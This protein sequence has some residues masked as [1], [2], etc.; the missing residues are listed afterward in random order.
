MRAMEAEAA[1][2]EAERV[3]NLVSY[4]EFS[5]KIQAMDAAYTQRQAK[6]QALNDEKGKVYDRYRS[7]YD[8]LNNKMQKIQSKYFNQD[9]LRTDD[10]IDN[11]PEYKSLLKQMQKLSDAEK[12]EMDRLDTEAQIPYASDYQVPG[13]KEYKDM[14]RVSFDEWIKKVPPFAYGSR[15]NFLINDPER[16]WTYMDDWGNQGKR[17]MN[18][19]RITALKTVL[20]PNTGKPYTDW[21]PDDPQSELGEYVSSKLKD[22]GE[23]QWDGYRG[24][25]SSIDP[26][27]LYRDVLSKG[28]CST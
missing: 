14:Q 19:S 2:R 9:T 20:N 24:M 26:T 27:E 21:H 4:S 3:A 1:Q 6:I 11:D 10:A 22:I 15:D 18:L 13:S 12:A 28:S 7:Q 16:R 5:N 23:I 17:P 8:V 25:G